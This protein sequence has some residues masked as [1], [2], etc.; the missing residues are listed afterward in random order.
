M[1]INTLWFYKYGI[2]S[3]YYALSR[4]ITVYS[5]I[6]GFIILATGLYSGIFLA[7]ADYQQGDVF[8]LM[9]VHVPCAWLSMMI[10]S[11]MAVSSIIYLT[12]GIKVAHYFS[13]ACA[14]LGVLFTALALITGA[15]WGRPTWGA[16]WVWGDARL[17]SELILFFI[18][19]LYIGLNQILPTTKKAAKTVAVICLIGACNLP[20]IHYSV[21]WWTS[22]HQPASIG[23][24]QGSAI[25][26]SML[27]PLLLSAVGFTLIF[28][29]LVHI[30][31]RTIIIQKDG[32]NPSQ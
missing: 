11:M 23:V 9:Y 16:W 32:Y 21:I 6:F 3:R 31:I 13:V 1:E 24:L 4:Y 15:I 25:D 27:Y 2:P 5:G 17:M 18:Y 20:I 28:F 29:S 19:L 30:K 12:W 26:I 14:P 22:L 10:Y 8:R 7:P